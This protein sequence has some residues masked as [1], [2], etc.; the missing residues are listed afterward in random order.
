MNKLEYR[1]DIDGLRAIAVLAV[2]IFHMN[3][4]W[5]PGGFIGVDIFFVISGYLIT[6]IIYRE[7]K[8]GTFSFQNFYKRRIKRILPV[9]FVVI[10]STL[11]ISFIIMLPRDI[12]LLAHSAFNAFIFFSNIYFTKFGG[13][14]DS[15]ETFPLLHT[16]SLSVEEQYY[17][18]WP[19]I[20]LILLKMG[21]KYKNFLKLIILLMLGSFIGAHLLSGS[22]EYST[23]SYYLLPTRGGELL[24]GSLLAF[25]H[26][27]KDK[28]NHKFTALSSVLGMALILASLVFINKSSVFPGIN[29]FWPTLG[30]ALIIYGSRDSFI[31]KFLSLK[32]LVYIGLISYSLY[33]WHWPIL[34]FLRYLSPHVDKSLSLSSIII[35]GILTFVCSILSY[36]FVEQPTRRLNF[37]FTQMVKYYLIIPAIFLTLICGVIHKTKG[38]FVAFNSK[39]VKYVSQGTCFNQSKKNCSIDSFKA[40]KQASQLVLLQG[41]SHAAHFEHFFRK[42]FQANKN[43]NFH[44]IASGACNIERDLSTISNSPKEKKLCKANNDIYSQVLNN[45]STVIFAGRWD[46][47]LFANKNNKGILTKNYTKK[48]NNLFEKLDNK[49]KKVVI[50]GQV[51]KYDIDI[52]KNELVLKKFGLNTKY[53]IDDNYIKANNK[54]KNIAN[55]FKNV[56]FLD[57]D[58]FFHNNG[59]Y[60]PYDENGIILYKDYHHLNLHGAEF[61]AKKFLNSSKYQS[62][63]TFLEQ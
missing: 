56:Y 38:N 37:N 2:I 19:V 39:L 11:L 31:N 42:A 36:H 32:F 7:M 40:N 17:L 9:F 28:I 20:L 62:F 26:S 41:D 46:D 55:Q 52:N 10:F 16:W 57:F 35:A 27:N 4:E 33:L 14:F 3:P 21:F 8:Q 58:E 50:L 25:I 5:L 43:Y 12:Y 49:R 29:A 47:S 44:L 51:P 59:S 34:A 22:D 63:K 18:I 15:P 54:L 45:Y 48:L 61:L 53:K 23:L 6:T 60:S 24:I 30:A 1:P 13:Y